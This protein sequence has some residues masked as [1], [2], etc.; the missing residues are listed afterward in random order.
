MRPRRAQH[1]ESHPRPRFA[2]IR[3]TMTMARHRTAAIPRAAATPRAAAAAPLARC[4]GHPPRTH[5]NQT[6]RRTAHRVVLRRSSSVEGGAGDVVTDDHV[7]EGHRGLHDALYGG[8]GEQHAAREYRS[9]EGE[10]GG[11]VFTLDDWVERRDGEKPTGLYAV[12]DE[13][14]TLQYIGYSRNLVR[15]VRRQRSRHGAS[16]STFVRIKLA[17]EGTIATRSLLEDERTRWLDA[18]GFGGEGGAVPVGN[19]AERSL[20]EEGDG[21]TPPAALS[22]S[23]AGSYEEG[24]LKMRRAMGE[25]LLADSPGDADAAAAARR[26]NTMRAVEGDDWSAV[27][28]AQTQQTVT[29]SPFAASP[30]SPA[31]PAASSPP[32][33]G[34]PAVALTVASAEA[35]LEEVRP[36]LLADGGDIRVVSADAETG[37]VQVALEGACGTCASAGQTMAMGVERALQRAFGNTLTKVERVDIGAP[38]MGLGGGG[39][40]GAD[41]IEVGHVDASLDALRPA[42]AGHGGAV[43]VLEVSADGVCAIAY[44]GP[45]PLAKGIAAA[46]KDKFP[47][48]KDVQVRPLEE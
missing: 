43:S 31:S 29:Q 24:K 46:I 39:G 28:D 37:V 45:P 9:Q 10:D 40:E 27:I 41:A 18:M 32:R 38:G 19:G 35:A 17:P 33:D 6:T 23:E 3:T 30:T 16:K 22:P 44:K 36:Y 12:Y 14:E 25:D 42:I 4:V 11:T 20:W 13:E 15:S 47:A 2:T 34:A 8:E 7:P 26:V 21:P 48:I 1:I 5:H